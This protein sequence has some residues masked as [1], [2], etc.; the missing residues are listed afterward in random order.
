MKKNNEDIDENISGTTPT[1]I[2]NALDPHT[3]KIEKYKNYS[4]LL[5]M[6]EGCKTFH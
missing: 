2:Y 6:K 1:Q 4:V 3:V 5:S